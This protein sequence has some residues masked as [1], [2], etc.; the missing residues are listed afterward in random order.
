MRTAKRTSI[1]PRLQRALGGQ[2]R[3]PVALP[4]PVVVER[5]QAHGADDLVARQADRVQR[6]GVVVALV[7][8]VVLEE[9]LRLDEHAA[10]DREVRRELVA[11]RAP[12]RRPATSRVVRKR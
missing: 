11:V 2:D 4:Q 12:A 8:V 3:E 9:P 1:A 6:R 5:I 10:P 7:A